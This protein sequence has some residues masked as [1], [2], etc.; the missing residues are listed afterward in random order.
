MDFIYVN[1]DF[2]QIKRV[3]FGNLLFEFSI[4]IPISDFILEE[5]AEISIKWVA[6]DLIQLTESEDNKDL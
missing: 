3:F 2:L 1:T 5:S 6:P 4:C